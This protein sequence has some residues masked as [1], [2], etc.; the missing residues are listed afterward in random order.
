MA[1]DNRHIYCLALLDL[2]HGRYLHDMHDSTIMHVAIPCLWHSDHFL[3]RDYYFLSLS[4]CHLKMWHSYEGLWAEGSLALL[5]VCIIHSEIQ[6]CP[7]YFPAQGFCLFRE[8]E[9]LNTE[10]GLLLQC[11]LL[12]ET[13]ESAEEGQPLL[14]F[15][16]CLCFPL[17][18]KMS[19]AGAS[20]EWR[21]WRYGCD[22]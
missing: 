15:Y 19:I 3:W 16:F 10:S 18:S 12:K 6:F 11:K 17:L 13:Y 14:Q 22:I 7:L 5:F 4:A 8:P 9:S 20:N 21:M 2:I 1:L